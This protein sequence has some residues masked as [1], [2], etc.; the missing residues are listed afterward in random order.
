[1]LLNDFPAP[2]THPGHPRCFAPSKFLGLRS[3]VY[4]AFLALNGIAEAFAYGVARSG[5]DVGR[6]GIA[7][8]AVGAAFASIAPG[9]VRTHGAA[10]P[11]AANCVA[12]G[13][14]AAHSMRLA[15]GY[16]A[17]QRHLAGGRRGASPAGGVPSRRMLPPAAALTEFGASFALTRLSRDRRPDRRHR[18]LGRRG[19]PARR[20]RGVVRNR[21]PGA[22]PAL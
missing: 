21:D 4:T 22:V 8:A 17:R 12:S 14:R 7:H 19:R 15:R 11:V 18:R 3:C 10:G 9:L 2:N 16:L 1:M 6:V 20:G 5:K 13:L